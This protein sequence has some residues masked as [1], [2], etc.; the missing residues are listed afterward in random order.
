[1]R[2][3]S[4]EQT[5]NVD[6]QMNSEPAAAI[7][8]EPYL[9][10]LPAT[11]WDQCANPGW[12]LDHAGTPFRSES[13]SFRGP[14]NDLES[15]SQPVDSEGEETE[16]T[17]QVT[18]YNPFISHAFLSSLEES[19]CAVA[20]T[21]WL[22]QHLILEG[23]DG[24]PDAVMPCYL[25]N[26]SQ[27]EYVFDYG[28]ADA[29]ER[30][31]GHYYPKLQVSVPF[32]PATGRRLL[33]S[34][35]ADPQEASVYLAAGLAELCKRHGASS[36]HLTFLPKAEWDLLGESGFLQRTDQQ[37]HWEDNG[38]G[39]FDGFL[40]A[41]S[42]RKRKN[43][44]R[45]RR[46][47]LASGDISI[48]WIAG[49]D[50]TEAHWDAFFQ[51]YID[52]GNRKWGRPY[53]NRT[54]FSLISERLG[55]RV[56]LILAKRAGRYIAGALNLAGSDTL[57]GRHWGCVEDHPFLHFEVCYYQAIDYAL[58]MGLS[59]VEAG[60][61]GAHKLARGYLPTTTYSAHFIANASF[62]DAIDRYLA[63]ERVAV[64]RENEALAEHAPFKRG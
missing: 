57:Y 10:Q 5:V 12:E 25:K 42:S 34:K 53:L 64:A 30:A 27:G 46:D 62:R 26:H 15:K 14:S 19:G 52:T 54:F 45:E 16:S 22:G 50:I 21:G 17:S 37:F 47:A 8:V 60:A 55:N 63:Q 56:I 36:A 51:F 41:L 58:A 23:P 11:D 6:L 1:M 20:E 3:E 43:L 33:L 2:R 9:K 32:T 61:Q 49:K 31:G 18:P 44:K 24:R 38:Y 59:R 7:R 13:K 48:E 4:G 39:D 29:F 40:A 35:D 28:W